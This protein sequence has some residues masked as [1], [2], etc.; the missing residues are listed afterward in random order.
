MH[1]EKALILFFKKQDNP[2]NYLSC[3]EEHFD[4][5][6]AGT[7]DKGLFLISDL[8][9]DLILL[10]LNFSESGGLILLKEIVARSPTLPVVVISSQYEKAVDA[11]QLGAS[12]FVNEPVTNPDV[13][14]HVIR[15]SL[16]R[17]KLIRDNRHYQE[18]LEQRIITSTRELKTTSEALKERELYYRKLF[19]H[20]ND[21]IIFFDRDLFIINVNRR[22][23]DLTGYSKIELLNKSVQDLSTIEKQ[24]S[25]LANVRNLTEKQ[26]MRFESIYERMDKS[27][28]D[29]EVSLTLIDQK[30]FIYQ[31]VVRDITESKKA[32]IAIRQNEEN[33]Q[34]TLNSIADA[35][36]S[37]DAQGRI[38]RMNPNAVRL[39]GWRLEDAL[40]QQIETL[41]QLEH[42]IHNEKIPSSIQDLLKQDPD[43]EKNCQL[44]NKDGSAFRISSTR[45]PIYDKDKRFVGLVVVF[46]DISDEYT[47]EKQLSHG[48]KM[49]AVGQLAGGIAHDFKNNLAAIISSAERLEMQLENEELKSIAESIA[50]AGNRSSELT[51]QLLNLSHETEIEFKPI[52][53]ESL[54][55]ELLHLIKHTFDKRIEISFNVNTL[56]SFV[57]GDFCLL[58]NAMLNILLNARDAMNHS[59]HIAIELNTVYLNNDYHSSQVIDLNKGDYLEVSI[60]DN[61]PGIAPDIIDRIFEP[62]FTSNKED[63][64]GLGLASVYACL[65][66]HNGNILVKSKMN[67]GACFKLLFPS[68]KKPQQKAFDEETLIPGSGHIMLVDD[69]VFLRNIMASSLTDLGY[70][71]TTYKD[72]LDAIEYFEVHH[73]N[74]D[75]IIL[76][77]QMPK[78]NGG[79]VLKE[80]KRIR[81]DVKVLIATGFS[82]NESSDMLFDQG[83]RGFISKPY[84]LG[85]LSKAI[86]KMLC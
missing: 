63:G 64:N 60:K 45:S 61:G 32:E 6:F 14:L 24:T 1:S 22:M 72:G 36:L 71:V 5:Q 49:E 43:L 77:M 65:R 38:T 11:L 13:L 55:H 7:A 3:L 31:L 35:V 83:I 27:L 10:D 25:F 47:T 8:S 82:Q 33:L 17:A 56:N 40:G 59:G 39:T 68:I 51:K 30:K 29:V 15:K 23:M 75:G 62:F 16:E 76:D 28:I 69:E 81:P 37:T 41:F 48:Q 21:G 66:K 70:E 20:S 44:V 4:V 46:R 34:I 80:L 74:V 85:R 42:A 79:E 18:Q 57:M 73:D 84:T 50:I 67:E 12:D 86:G 58:Q 26:R 9:P 78:M 54:I 19:E 53:L 52:E 2:S